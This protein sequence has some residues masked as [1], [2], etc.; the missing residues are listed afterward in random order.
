M[1]PLI[2]Y[3][4]RVHVPPTRATESLQRRF[5]EDPSLRQHCQALS[6]RIQDHR[7]QKN[8]SEFFPAIQVA[9]WLK[10]VRCLS[11][12]G[13]FDGEQNV[14]TWL[15]I[16]TFARFLRRLTHLS[17][18]RCSWGLHL[19]PMME[20]IQFPSLKRLRVD[21]ISETKHKAVV[22]KPEVRSFKMF[23]YPLGSTG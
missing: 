1:L 4:F 23:T 7:P 22:L 21:G 6:I 14:L 11:I 20:L 19:T 9:S 13:G 10:N 2:Y 17:I 18:C 12:H 8:S 15:S 16:R 3:T 5:V